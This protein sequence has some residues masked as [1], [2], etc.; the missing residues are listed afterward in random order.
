M[1]ELPGSLQAKYPKVQSLA[2]DL[3]SATW[4]AKKQILSCPL[5]AIH[6]L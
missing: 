4:K 1:G 5:T 2:T 6:M 3:V